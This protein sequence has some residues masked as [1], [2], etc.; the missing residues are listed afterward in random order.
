[1]K[2]LELIQQHMKG[3]PAKPPLHL[4]NP[5][6]SGDIDIV[7]LENGDW[8]HQGGKINRLP[9]VKLF[10]SILRREEDGEYYLV[11]PVEK[12][13]IK[14]VDT[15]FVVIEMDVLNKNNDDQQ[16]IF[17]TNV[18]DKYLLNQSHPLSVT[19]DVSTH[20]PHPVIRCEHGLTAR[21]SRAVFYRLVEIAVE[22][23]GVISVVSDGD[24]FELGSA[25]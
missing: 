22:R 23:D 10:A 19:T 5:S 6:L 3:M 21:L 1:M 7:I 13:R 4:W 2:G 17:T 12:W 20:E 8:M 11:T 14:V 16:I 24:W 18:A 15:A 9:L 25:D